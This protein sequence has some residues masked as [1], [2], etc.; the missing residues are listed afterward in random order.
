MYMYTYEI[1]QGEILLKRDGNTIEKFY[2]WGNN[3]EVKNKLDKIFPSKKLP[4]M[5]EI[6]SNL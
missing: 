4:E 1:S 6:L 5:K 2:F 3:L